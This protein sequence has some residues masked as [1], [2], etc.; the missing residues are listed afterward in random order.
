MPPVIKAAFICDYALTSD[1]GK[2]SAMGIFSN[3]NFPTMPNAYPRFFVVII[4]SLDEG[5][6]PV[7]LG[8]VDAFGQQMLEDQPAVDV[9]VDVPGTDTN[10]V[11]DFNNL[12]FN[13]PGIHQ[14]Q[15]FLDGLLIHSVP[16]SVQILT[17]PN[18]Q[19]SR[20]N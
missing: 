16:L 8:I 7:S 18:Q 9:Q 1:D 14:V 6:H 13:Q 17:I 12:P 11:I 2:L 15:L 19:P 20:P 10:L 4:L 5:G 3:I